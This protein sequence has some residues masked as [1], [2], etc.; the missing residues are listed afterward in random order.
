MPGPTTAVET[1]TT[2]PSPS[3]SAP[4]ELPGCSAASV[5]ITF[6][7]SRAAPRPPAAIARPSALT[8]P[9]LTDPA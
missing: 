2:R 9:A 6:S 4:P 8:T 3:A 5:W 7:T 1:P